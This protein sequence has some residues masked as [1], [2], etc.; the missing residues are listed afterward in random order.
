MEEAYDE[1]G[2]IPTVCG[3]DEDYGDLV[4]E[5]TDPRPETN[6]IEVKGQLVRAADVDLTEEQQE[7]LARYERNMGK[8]WQ[9]DIEE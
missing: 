9:A 1:N 5:T 6:L 8:T 3:H 4:L 2:F 7:Q